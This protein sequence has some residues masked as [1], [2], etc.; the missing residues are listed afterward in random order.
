VKYYLFD[1]DGTL[2]RTA[3][4]G[5]R[6][7]EIAFRAVYGIRNG[8]EDIQ[9]MGRTDPSILE[10]AL[11]KH[12]ISWDEEE[13]TRFRR[14]YFNV[15][16]KEIK[17]PRRGKRVCRGV[18]GLL[19]SLRGWHQ[20]RLG[21]LTGNWRASAHLK[22]RHFNL[23]QY[24][25]TG[26]FADDSSDRNALVPVALDRFQEKFGLSVNKQDTYVIGDTPLDV[27]CAKPH[28][29]RSVAVATGFH[30]VEELQAAAPDYVFKDFRDTSSAFRVLTEL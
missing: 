4:A 5:R 8:F 23:D 10:E 24:F 20:C 25:E 26:A 28:G 19:E 16:E 17:A 13:V 21:L 12:D 11:N 7:L 14:M 22:L 15:L 18:P 3:G 27:K 1:I 6:S 29:V 30:S 2:V 9:M